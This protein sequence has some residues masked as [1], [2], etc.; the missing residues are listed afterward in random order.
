MSG[1]AKQDTVPTARTAIM[2]VT[3]SV[4]ESEGHT[5]V[6]GLFGTSHGSTCRTKMKIESEQDHHM[7]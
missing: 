7:F 5:R 2:E 4:E 3:H 6:C 1:K